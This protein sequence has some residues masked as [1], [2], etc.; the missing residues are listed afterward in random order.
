[1]KSELY[2]YS[3]E[4]IWEELTPE[5]RNLARLIIYKDKYKREEVLELMG[6]KSGNYSMYRDRLR[7]RGIISAKQGYISI[8]PPFLAEYIRDYC[9]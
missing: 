3:Y 2:A 6:E 9:L 1:M 4:K 7:K 5:D 8:Y